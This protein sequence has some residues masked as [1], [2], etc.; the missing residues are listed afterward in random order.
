METAVKAAGWVVGQALAPVTGGLLEAWAASEGLGPNVEALKEELL[1]AQALLDNAQEREIRSAALKELLHKL[2]QLAYGADDVL[3]ELEYF[4]IQDEIDGTYHAAD[5]HAGGC[6]C[7]LALN[8]RHTARAVAARLLKPSPSSAGSQHDTIRAGNGDQDNKK[9]KKLG[10]LSSICSS[11]GGRSPSPSPT[12]QDDQKTNSRCLQKLASITRSSACGLVGNGRGMSPSQSSPA[13]QFVD[14]KVGCGCLQKVVTSTACNTAQSIGKLLPCCSFQPVNG[15]EKPSLCATWK[16]RAQQRKN[17]S[18]QETK[19]KFNRVEISKKMKDIIE[20]LKLVCAKVSN[21]LNLEFLGTTRITKKDIAMK[22]PETTPYITENEFFGRGVQK[23]AVRDIIKRFADKEELVVLPIVGPGG[24]GKTTFVQQIYKEFMRDFDI[25][26]WICVSLNFNASKLAQEAR[27]KIPEVEG[28]K[29][30]GS[31]QELIEQILEAKRFLVVLDDIWEC[32]EDEWKKLLAPFE[33]GAKKGCMIIVTTRFPKVADMVIKAIACPIQ[34]ERLEGKDFM[35]FFQSCAFGVQ[36]SWENHP[37]L[38]DVGEKIVI[39]LKG[40]PLAAKTVGRLLRNQLTLEHWT[41]VLESKEW[42]FQT[43]EDD[44]MPA[45]KLSYDYL[46]FHL[47]Q[48]FYYCAL[49]PEDY[50][51]DSK[52]LIHLWIGLDIVHPCDQNRRIEDVGQSYLNDLVS[53]GFLKRNERN[54]GSPYFV[55]HDLLHDLAVNISSFECLTICSSNINSIQ[56]RQDVRHLS[57][58]VDK[59]DVEDIKTFKYCKSDLDTLDKRLK[60]ENLRTLMV[61]GDYQGSFAKTFC[62]LFKKAKTLRAIYLSGASYSMDDM[63]HKLPK[64]IHLRYLRIKSAYYLGETNFHLSALLRLYHL[65]VVDLHQ[66]FGLSGPTRH[67]SNLPKLHYFMVS[68]L[69]LQSDIF[70]VGKLKMLQELRRFQVRKEDKGFELNQLGQLLEL[71]G[72]LA[73]CNL[74]RIRSME[75]ARE[76]RIIQLKCLHKLTL[77]WDANR[78]NKDTAH[79]EN[80]L[81]ILI[82]HSNLHGLCIRGHGGTKCPKWLGENH[83]IKNLESLCLDGVAWEL[84]PPIGELLVDGPRDKISSNIPNTTFQDLRRLEFIKLQR[85]EHW[86]VNAPCQLFAHLEVLIIKDCPKLTQLTFSHSTCCHGEKEEKKSWFPSLQELEIKDCP[87]LQQFPPVPWRRAQCSAKIGGVG[88]GLKQLV[89]QKNYKSEY[90]LEIEGK[91]APDRMQW[92]I[93]AFHNLPELK[94]LKL[95]RCPP[96]SLRHLQMLSSLKK[97][98][99]YHSTNVFVLDESESCAQYRFPIEYMSIEQCG[100]TGKELTHLLTCT[101]NLSNFDLQQCNNIRGLD[102]ADQQQSKATTPSPS[103]SSSGNEGVD[104]VQNTA[105]ALAA[106][107]DGVLLLPPQLQALGIYSCPD[108]VLHFDPLDDSTEAA[109]RTG[110]RGGGL[111]GLKSLQSLRIYFCPRF[112]S[113]YSWSSSSSSYAPFPTSLKELSLAGGVEGM[114]TLLPLSNLTSLTHL[115]ISDC[116]DLRG[117]GLWPLLAQGHLTTLTVY[118]T[119]N[120]FV[121]SERSLSHEQELPSSS[122]EPHTLRTDDVAGILSTTICKLLSSWLTKLEFTCVDETECFTEKQEEALVLLTSIEEIR[123][124][125]C[126]KLQGLPAGLHGHSKLKRFEI[127]RCEAIQSLPKDGLPASLRELKIASCPAIKALPKDCL[128][129]SLQILV[130]QHCKVIRDLPKD[131]LPSSMEKLEILGCPA[132]RSLPKVDSLPNSLRELDVRC[133]GSEELRRQCRK[134]IGMI[135]IVRV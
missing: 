116:G 114:E 108:V 25:P 85:L 54:G 121:G 1:Y 117:E 131:G 74:E 96:L 118:K 12:N 79:E 32:H 92:D 35:D 56:I 105:A 97:L 126:K 4:R 132:M 40:F 93:L 91:D 70:E 124:V 45:L 15:N 52:E 68:D 77:E 30:K 11:C 51:F 119:P 48:C 9:D 123:F 27:E 128:P 120:F 101:P 66:C 103:P 102:V 44:I 43:N 20:H 23:D 28:E 10:C 59:K 125:F 57:I 61:F 31:D 64:L 8:A 5:E 24:I 50:E 82:P 100:V 36:Q 107:D 6:V 62:D 130:I 98:E 87:E 26:I 122:S 3:D 55:V 71:G 69:Q 14:K 110:E 104:E 53:H 127:Y 83:S 112:F 22:R 135:P 67:M 133:S 38:R 75:E 72:S 7:G 18:Q 63:L 42:E 99:V 17:T 90:S 60:V 81:E 41:T 115:T 29:K 34:M 19:M 89:C 16:T 78:P 58:I 134:L 47:Q 111:Q 109:P 39:K 76:A 129:S 86:V 73:I 46:P 33:R 106:D 2:R 13:N 37:K 49:F 88:S 113:S 80:A 65:E 84:F 95:E 21:V 94:E